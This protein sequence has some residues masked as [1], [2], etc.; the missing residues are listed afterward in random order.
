LYIKTQLIQM[1]H[2]LSAFHFLRTTRLQP[3][4]IH[5]MLRPIGVACASVVRAPSR[6]FVG[7]KPRDGLLKLK[8]LQIGGI[9]S[10]IFALQPVT[11]L[12]K[13]KNTKAK[14][15]DTLLRYSSTSR[16]KCSRES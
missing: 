9:A 13:K 5:N 6:R 8:A 11:V 14:S 1:K 16:E 2:A 3:I 12:H 10:L 7:L 15:E 4:P